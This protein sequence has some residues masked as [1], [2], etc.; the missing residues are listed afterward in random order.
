MELLGAWDT[1]GLGGPAG[2]EHNGQTGVVSIIKVPHHGSP[3]SL[4]YGFYRRVQSGVAVI[5]V[6]PNS[7]GHPSPD[8]IHAAGES[9]LAVFRTDID[10]AVKV[11]IYPARVK[12]SKFVK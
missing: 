6:G 3:D 12:V 5:S 9:G 8:V 4:V 11:T 7:Y 10:G 2:L 1:S